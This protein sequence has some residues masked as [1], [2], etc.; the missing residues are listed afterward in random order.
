MYE[1]VG[2]E[3]AGAAKMIFGCG[4]GPTTIVGACG[5]T[6]TGTWG[7]ETITGVETIPVTGATCCTGW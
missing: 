6:T 7:G 1:I 4:V 5:W 2:A 3:G